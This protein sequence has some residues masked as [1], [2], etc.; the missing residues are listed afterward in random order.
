MIDEGKFLLL[1]QEVINYLTPLNTDMLFDNML[2]ENAFE[3]NKM[4][5]CYPALFADAYNI[6]FTTSEIK[7]ITIAG[8][9]YFYSLLKIDDLFDAASTK[10][11]EKVMMFILKSHEEA[12]KILSTYFSIQSPFW[13][14]WNSLHQT[15][16]DNFANEIKIKSRKRID[17][18]TYDQLAMNRNVIGLIA[19]SAV[20]HLQHNHEKHKYQTLSAIHNNFAIAYQI[21]DDIKDIKKDYENKQLNFVL[22][23]LNNSRKAS[24]EGSIDRKIKYFYLSGMYKKVYKRLL[25][26]IEFGIALS[27]KANAGIWSDALYKFKKVASEELCN[28]TGFIKCIK[29]RD[30]LTRKKKSR[31][32]SYKSLLTGVSIFKKLHKTEQETISFLFEQADQ[33]FGELKHVI[34]LNKNIGLTTSNEIHVNDTFQRAIIGDVLCDCRDILGID[35]SRMLENEAKYLVKKRQR[36]AIGGWSYYPKIEEIAA[37]ADDLGQIL[38]L[39]VR[40]DKSIYIQ[41]FISHPLNILL[42]ERTNIDGGIETWIIPKRSIN[43]THLRQ[44][45][46]NNMWGTGPDAEVMANLVYG[47]CL[48]DFK[49]YYKQIVKSCKYIISHRD[50][51][52][53]WQSKWYYGSYYGTYVVMRL[54]TY[55][56]KK[57]PTASTNFLYKSLNKTIGFFETSQQKDGGWSMNNNKSELLTSALAVLAL[58]NVYNIRKDVKIRNQVL[59]GYQYLLKTSNISLYEPYN[60]PFIKPRINDPYSSKTITVSYIAKA[61]LEIRKSGIL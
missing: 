9:L 60:I 40:L 35:L 48:Y 21:L 14:S 28:M 41:K 29:I 12:I 34:Y 52:G 55:V 15:Y 16:Y 49:L 50:P 8:Y 23:K 17:E 4:F 45:K 24:L 18:E 25:G 37:D 43:I 39:F 22:L 7:Q 38:Q 54:I 31:P 51:N 30:A 27:K 59:K 56:L 33:G 11:G 58:L 61:F 26:K 32:D 2:S 36:D 53:S 19:L 57:D 46:Y 47:L 44:E 13:Q 10:M 42:K 5:L 20:Y 1:K 6:K 3:S